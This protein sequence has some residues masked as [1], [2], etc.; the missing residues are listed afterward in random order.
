MCAVGP[1]VDQV[2]LRRASQGCEGGAAFGRPGGEL[3]AETA[4]AGV[5]EHLPASLGILELNESGGRPVVLARVGGAHGDQVVLAG[6]T[7]ERVDE[8]AIEVV[9]EQEDDRATA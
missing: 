5:D 9:A 8:S 4:A 7:A 1:D 6:R 2:N 3:R